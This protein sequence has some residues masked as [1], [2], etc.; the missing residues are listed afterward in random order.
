MNSDSITNALTVDVEDYFHVSAFARVLNRENWDSMESRVEQNTYKLLEIFDE[1]SVSATFFVLGWV[2]DRY[3]NLVRDI[4]ANGHELACHGFSH[5]LIY[6]QDPAEFRQETI[7][8]KG[9]LEDISGWP[10]TGYRAASYSITNKSRW[11][12]DTLIDA[13]F[14]YDSSIVP[15]RHDLYGM[16]GVS[17]HPYRITAADGRSMIEFPPSTISVVGNRIPIGGGGYFRLFP[18]WFSRWGLN[19]VNNQDGMPFS[20]YLHPWEVDPEQPRIS[21]GWKSRFRHYNNLE[22]CEG[23]LIRLLGEF[24]FS[25]MRSVLADLSLDDVQAS[26]LGT[27]VIVASRATS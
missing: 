20:F 14:Q 21:A 25:T 18:Y 7:R 11:A 4:C 9:L 26:R 10:V 12:I 16:T 8:A 13:G 3:P 24:R 2:A 17:A 19:R 27:P 1:A 15:V 22:K 5:Q 6:T 23:R